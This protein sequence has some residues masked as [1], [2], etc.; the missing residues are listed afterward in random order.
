MLALNIIDGEDLLFFPSSTISFLFLFF[1]FSLFLFFS[2]FT[3]ES[4]MSLCLTFT[5]LFLI[6]LFVTI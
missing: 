6:H 2:F 1:F 4:T 5:C 3:S